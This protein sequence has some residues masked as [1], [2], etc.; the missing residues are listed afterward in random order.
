MYFLTYV[1]L[2]YELLIQ[3]EAPWKSKQNYMYL[4]LTPKYVTVC[5]HLESQF[6]V[7]VIVNEN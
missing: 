7:H 5:Q 3:E 6:L 4:D 2:K 1:I